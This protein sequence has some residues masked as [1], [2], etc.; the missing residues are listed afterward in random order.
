MRT[1]LSKTTRRFWI[2]A[3]VMT[4]HLIFLLLRLLI[5]AI[6]DYEIEAKNCINLLLD[7]RGVIINQV[8]RDL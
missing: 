5:A 3:F 2:I 1:D 4:M 8:L 6:L 7:A